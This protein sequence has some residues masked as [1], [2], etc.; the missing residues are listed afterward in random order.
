MKGSG[1]VC[2]LER[3]GKERF[4]MSGRG[5][6]GKASLLEWSGLVRNG[7]SLGLGRIG[8][9]CLLAGEGLVSLVEG[10]GSVW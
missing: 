8:S 4:G 7:M 2:L 10:S 3:V 1:V 9:V 6:F 5:G